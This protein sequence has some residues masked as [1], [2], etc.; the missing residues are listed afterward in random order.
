MQVVRK[1]LED[2]S[3]DDFPV[4]GTIEITEEFATRQEA[5]DWF[6]R[7]LTKAGYLPPSDL[8][9]PAP[10]PAPRKAPLCTETV[11]A[12]EKWCGPEVEP[13]NPSEP[14]NY[15]PEPSGKRGPHPPGWMTCPDEDGFVRENCGMKLSELVA[16]FRKQF[17]ESFRVDGAIQGRKYHHMKCAGAKPARGNPQSGWTPEER[18][19]AER[20]ARIEED[21]D[22]IIEFRNLMP[23]T[24]RSD[25]AIRTKMSIIRSG[26]VAAGG[27]EPAHHNATSPVLKDLLRKRFPVDSKV[28][29]LNLG[30][31]E[32]GTVVAHTD[33]SVI[34]DTG[35]EKRLECSPKHIRLLGAEA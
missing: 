29:I 23:G 21:V 4:F 13:T 25:G 10:R 1:I 2:E 12:D 34:L 33:H 9:L 14:P 5:E 35:G 28:K 27:V 20:C 32:E 19:A 30:N 24:S 22:R 3:R 18:D 7:I 15:Q 16:A 17:P 6:S 8:P 31:G 26:L 11:R